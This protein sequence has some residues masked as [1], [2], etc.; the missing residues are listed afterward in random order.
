LES[1][2]FYESSSQYSARNQ[3]VYLR[4]EKGKGSH[5][6]VGDINNN[7]VADENEFQQVRYDGDYIPISV[8]TDQLQPV[9]DLKASFRLKLNPSREIKRA[10]TVYEHIL[11]NIST[12]SNIQINEVNSTPENQN[13]Y[14]LKLSNF[15]ND[16]NT[17]SGSQS[18]LQ[19]LFLLDRSS[20]V[21]V[22][23][24]YNERRNLTQYTY[25]IEKRHVIDRSVR[26]RFIFPDNITNE[27]TLSSVNDNSLSKGND[28]RNY[29]IRGNE[30]STSF[31]Y[32]PVQDLEFVFGLSYGKK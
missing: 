26:F 18:F 27:T 28:E 20:F 12:E 19:D 13:I 23:L 10:T 22:R 7:N 14:L 4:V 25:G 9:T 16:S 1:N 3:K 30:L 24:R 31:S 32:R 21:N 11:S 8:K 17:V 6:Y 15:L 2:L 29:L 5:A